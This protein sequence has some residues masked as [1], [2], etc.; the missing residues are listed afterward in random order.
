MPPTKLRAKR[1]SQAC[2]FCHRR[3]LKC[4]TDSNPTSTPTERTFCLTCVEY[5]QE[6]TRERR[7]KKRGTKPR[8]VNSPARKGTPD[9][10]TTSTQQPPLTAIAGRPASALAN[11]RTMTLLLDVYLDSIHPNFPVFCEREL[12][13]G[14]RDGTFPQDN[15]DYMSLMCLCALSAQHVGDGALFNEDD[16]VNTVE[17]TNL[18]SDYIAEAM[19]LVPINFESSDLNLVRSYALLTLLG[20]QTGDNAM[21]H[22]FLGLCHGV[23]AQLN[24]HD[25][26]RWPRTIGECE[27]EVRRRLW[28]SIYR[29][30]VHTACV[31]GNIVRTPERR[32]GVGYPVGA[33]HPAFIPGRNGQYEDWFDG[34]NTT[35]DLYRVL[36]HAISDLRAKNRPR[37]QQS[38][39]GPQIV[40]SDSTTIMMRLAQIQEHLL[41]QF[42]TPASR[43]DDSGRNRCGF[44]TPNIICTIHLAR[45]LSCIAGENDPLLAC[46][47]AGDLVKNIMA[48]PVEYMRATGSPL[49]QQLAGVGHILV[50][51]AKKNG[52]QEIHFIKIKHVIQ[53]IVGLVELLRSLKSYMLPVRSRLLQ[54]KL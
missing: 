43:S 30:E 14:W 4:K 24:L 44:Q 23:C 25:E 5:G 26:S 52:L 11:R 10:V 18:R 35:T 2:D 20:A 13:V 50:G 36:E 31:L 19:H 32:C 54:L 47:L 33:H 48:I 51:I 28:W 38:I 49:I 42:V 27:T 15:S 9:A 3:G 45:L 34:W 40:G 6:C 12:W 8:A 17:W 22:R 21:L 37:H 39:L 41:P 29:L 46:S 7:P 1:V 16:N 53:S